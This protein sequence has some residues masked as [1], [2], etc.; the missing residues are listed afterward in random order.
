MPLRG[1]GSFFLSNR[2]FVSSGP[3]PLLQLAPNGMDGLKVSEEDDGNKYHYPLY[4]D[5]YN[6]RQNSY[7]QF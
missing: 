1:G 4:D 6:E 3:P 5:L 7:L 2:D